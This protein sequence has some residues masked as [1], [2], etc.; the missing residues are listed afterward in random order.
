MLNTIHSTINHTI[1]S[2][3]Q[4]TR[5]SAINYTKY[6]KINYIIYSS[7]NYIM[8]SSTVQYMQY[9]GQYAIQCTMN[10][11]YNTQCNINIKKCSIY[12]TKLSDI[13]YII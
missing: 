9:T 6:S 8:I 10:L 5:H 13:H 2:A 11:L 4:Y 1:H 3:M 7:I 12:F